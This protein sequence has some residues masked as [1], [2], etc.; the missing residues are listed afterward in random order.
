MQ[1]FITGNHLDEL[2]K[3]ET[4]DLYAQTLEMQAKVNSADTISL[5]KS[6]SQFN[7]ANYILD[8]GCGPAAFANE[9]KELIGKKDYIGIDLEPSF[10]Q[11]AKDKFRNNNNFQ[12]FVSDI[13]KFEKGLFDIILMYAVLQHVPSPSKALTY[14][15]SKLTKNGSL[16][17]LD[18]REDDSETTTYP[19]IPTLV[20]MYSSLHQVSN[21]RGRNKDC[22]MESEKWAKENGFRVE[23]KKFTETKSA[24]IDEKNT[25][26]L[27]TL[28]ISELLERFYKLKTDQNELATQLIDWSNTQDSYAIIT[29]GVWLILSR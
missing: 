18:T 14:L 22:I 15:S 27:Y 25:F 16:I 17:L 26:I 10:I 3:I 19:I 20:K 23:K 2:K 12:F 29:G 28:Y 7:K 5:F 13:H 24:T 6:L 8:A 4:T 21:E 11:R 1:S 9:I